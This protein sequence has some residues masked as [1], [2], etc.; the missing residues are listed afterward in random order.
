M[1]TQIKLRRDTA[2]NWSNTNPVLALGEAGYDTTNNEIRVGDGTSTWTSLS[3]IG[4]GLPAGM[5]AS[6]WYSAPNITNDPTNSDADSIQFQV[7]TDWTGNNVYGR[8]TVS[9]HDLNSSMYSHLQADPYG[10]SIRNAAWTGGG[11]EH[12]W[13]FMSFEGQAYTRFPNGLLFDQWDGQAEVS[14]DWIK[15][16]EG[17][18]VTGESN[19]QNDSYSVQ[20][21]SATAWDANNDYGRATLSWHEWDYSRYSHVHVDPNGAAIRLASWNNSKGAN[22]NGDGSPA[23]EYEITWG[24]N[25]DGTVSFPTG[26]EG[27]PTT[28]RFGMGNLFVVQDSG[29][30]I[31]ELNTTTGTY[32]G[33]G[34]R[35]NPGIE[36]PIDITMPGV[37]TANIAPLAI[38]N[39]AGGGVTIAATPIGGS[40]PNT[41]SFYG[42]GVTSIPGSITINNGAK[43]V[44]GLVTTGFNQNQTTVTNGYLQVAMNS[45]GHV[46]IASSDPTG[47]PFQVA[48]TGTFTNVSNGNVTVVGS[49][50]QVSNSGTPSFTITDYSNNPITFAN[51]GDSLVLNLQTPDL[52]RIYRVTVIATDPNNSYTAG[53]SSIVIEQLV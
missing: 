38:S 27:P 37:S 16:Y 8:S 4:G 13:E 31:G 35:I 11:Y 20:M 3:P 29:W 45:S 52:G 48:Y 43:E 6:E 15:L 14:N 53:N 9:W 26:Y 32:G 28:Q 19:G 33:D 47:N 49:S 44:F 30:T 2:T 5:I 34:I 40:S 21:Q 42:N 7:Q 17:G 51:R 18:D 22:T 10:V 39:W 46:L 36:G 50:Y 24:F 23:G 41:W 12:Y 25:N 1:T